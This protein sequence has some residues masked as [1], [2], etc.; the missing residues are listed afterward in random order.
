MPAIKVCEK[1]CA[2]HWA[3]SKCPTC[4]DIRSDA[5]LDDPR[6]KAAIK[7]LERIV[8]GNPTCES[9]THALDFSVSNA[10]AALAALQEAKDD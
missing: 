5:I 1:C 3:D 9:A 2:A 6:V 4:N 8:H 10:R 7:A